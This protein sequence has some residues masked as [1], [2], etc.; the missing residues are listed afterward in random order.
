MRKGS[1]H[2]RIAGFLEMVIG[3]VS[4]V[5]IRMLLTE[6]GDAVSDEAAKDAL[7]GIVGLYVA[8]GFKILAGLLGILLANKKSLLTVI[9]GVVLFFAH[10]ITFLQGGL[11]TTQI[12]IYALLMVIPYYYLHNAV[13]NYR[14]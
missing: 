5:L 1:K 3:V 10:L 7:F 4:I 9:C 14:D 2:L 12:I 13:R 6:G 11:D 8:D